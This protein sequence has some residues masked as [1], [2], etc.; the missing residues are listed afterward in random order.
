MGAILLLA[1]DLLYV[2]ACHTLGIFT[3]VGLPESPHVLRTTGIFRISRNPM[4]A[5]FG[6]FGSAAFLLASGI[7]TTLLGLCCAVTHHKIILAE[8][9]FL[10]AAFPAEY[11]QYRQHTPRYL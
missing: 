9:K 3:R 10:Q 7:P 6:F 5:A 2:P 1:G 8:E 11:E 4:Y